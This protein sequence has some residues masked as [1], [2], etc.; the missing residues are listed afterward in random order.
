M[1]TKEPINY[2]GGADI[3]TPPVA[4]ASGPVRRIPRGS[5]KVQWTLEAGDVGRGVPVSSFPD[6]TIINRNTGGG[7][8]YGTSTFTFKGS[9]NSTDG[10][11]G[12]WQTLADKQGNAI[13]KTADGV[14]SVLENPLWVRPEYSAGTGTTLVAELLAETE[15]G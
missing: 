9:N 8:V 14:E 2:S 10:E 7:A 5:V 15:R 13:S 12:T 11:D 1:A 4:G 3:V 6:K